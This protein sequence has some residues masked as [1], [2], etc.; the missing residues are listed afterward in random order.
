MWVVK[1]TRPDVSLII[2]PDRNL[3]GKIVETHE[4][5]IENDQLVEVPKINGELAPDATWLG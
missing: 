2:L 5:W 3:Q 1:E 4:R